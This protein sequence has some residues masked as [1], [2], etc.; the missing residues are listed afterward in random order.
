MIKKIILCLLLF[1]SP[2]Y[3][4]TYY[5]AN[6]PCSGNLG[7]GNGSDSNAGTKAA[8][9]LT[10]VY[11]MEHISG[12]DTLIIDDGTYIGTGNAINTTQPPA[13]TTGSWTIIKA[14]ND[15]KVV[16]DGQS[17]NN[18]F[19]VTSSGARYW[20]FEGLIWG[21]GVG[22][23]VYGSNYSYVK[24]LRC[25]AYNSASGNNMN[26]GAAAN[27]ASYILFEGCY[28]WG[29]GRYKFIAGSSSYIVFRNCVGRPDAVNAGGEPVAVF[30][31]YSA[32]YV[33]FQ[34]CIAI[35]ADQI[36]YWTNI[37][38]RQGSFFVP[39]TSAQSTNIAFD[40]CIGLNVKWGSIEVAQNNPTE[41]IYFRNLVLWD[42]SDTGGWLIAIRNDAE[43]VNCTI[44]DSSADANYCDAPAGSLVIKN[45]IIYGNTI[46]NG[47]ILSL[48]NGSQAEDYNVFYNNNTSTIFG[49]TM[50]AHSV[51]NV[52]PITSIS[53]LVKVETSSAMDGAGSGGADIGANIFYLIGTSGTLYGET[54]Y[55]TETA[56]KMWPF[57]NEELIRSKMAAYTWDDGSGGD[58]E[59]TGTRGFATTSLTGY[60][61]NYLEPT[62]TITVTS[63]VTS[64]DDVNEY[65]Y[66]ES[67][68]TDEVDPAMAFNNATDPEIITSGYK[69]T[70]TGTSSDANGIDE[71]K[72]RKDAAPDATHGTVCTGTTSWSCVDVPL[73]QG[74][75]TYYFECFDPSGNGGGVHKVYNAPSYRAQAGGAYNVR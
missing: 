35:D 43:I 30:T 16:F 25:G 33:A 27:G 23:N 66:G 7:W 11:A 17:T 29:T 38:D 74:D 53:Y 28:A 5:M 60:I 44:G 64:T 6:N 22:T 31:A 10:L 18:M 52:N 69:V 73:T 42:N 47:Y 45:N 65:I 59:I 54:G 71:C 61:L 32:N 72:Y 57:P 46:A 20:Q 51:T 75:N 49:Q 3:A 58:P 1:S 48:V 9:Y 37:G 26:W 39:T 15:G 55:A 4:A 24:F 21:N 12:G 70:V 41:N 67:G 68:E 62:N 56:I 50:G 8:P 2:L 34:N 36:A 19:Y 14:E 63:N 13:G 40:N